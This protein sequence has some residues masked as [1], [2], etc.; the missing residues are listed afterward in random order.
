MG[1]RARHPNHSRKKA[2]QMLSRAAGEVGSHFQV[3]FL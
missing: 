3:A 2:E 1:H